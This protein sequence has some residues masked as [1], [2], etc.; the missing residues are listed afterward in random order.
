M[1][2]LAHQASAAFILLIRPKEAFMKLGYLPFAVLFLFA[3]LASGDEADHYNRISFSS[4]ASRKVDNDLL[5]VRMSVEFNGKEPARIAQQLNAVLKEAFRKAEAYSTVK[6]LTG[7]QGTEPVYGKNEKFIGYRGHAEIILKSR[8]FEAVAKL[9][10]Q[11]QDAMRLVGVDFSISPELRKQVEGELTAE[12]M[13]AFRKQ[14]DA[15]RVM[16]G[17]ASY[18]IVRINISRAYAGSRMEM[19]NNI[20]VSKIDNLADQQQL[21]GGQGEV[22]MQV[23]GT[24]EIAP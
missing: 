11:L 18:K 4:E 17:G 8:D 23:A 15:V 14:A 21:H 22:G 13:A 6:V 10:A 1:L 20:G 5:I 9:I 24:I 16:L 2:S 3:P 7:D 19:M 12:A